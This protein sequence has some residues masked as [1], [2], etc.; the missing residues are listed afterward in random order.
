MPIERSF[1]KRLNN[2]HMLREFPFYNELNVLKTSRTFEAY[3]S[4]II[5]K[6]NSTDPSVYIKH[7]NKFMFNKTKYQHQEHFF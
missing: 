4:Y 5:E 2:I 6:L 7:F 3:P 1:I